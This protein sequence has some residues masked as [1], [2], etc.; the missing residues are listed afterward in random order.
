M[1]SL[2][3]CR[4]LLGPACRPSNEQLEQM[5]QELYALAEMI[6]DDLHQR[7]R[8][9]KPEGT[10]N[11]RPRSSD[12]HRP[13]KEALTLVPPRKLQEVEERGAILQ[14]DAGMARKEAERRELLESSSTSAERRPLHEK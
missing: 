7:E 2:E 9:S 3:R 12:S 11:E 14:F 13:V 5:R 4:S 10:S 8:P 1:L 6:M